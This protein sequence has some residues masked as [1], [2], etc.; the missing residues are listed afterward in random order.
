MKADWEDYV[1]IIS[2]FVAANVWISGIV[3]GWW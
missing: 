3:W 1:I 2:A